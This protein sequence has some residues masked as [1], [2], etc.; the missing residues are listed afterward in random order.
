M[1]FKGSTNCTS[2]EKRSGSLGGGAQ[3]KCA[4]GHMALRVSFSG[5]HDPRTSKGKVQKH[6]P[7]EA[8]LALHLSVFSVFSTWSQTE[9]DQCLAS[10]QMNKNYLPSKYSIPDT[11]LVAS[12]FN[13]K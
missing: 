7:F 5:Y 6:S 4:Q 3:V 11:L 13:L 12:Q 2:Q 1:G 9:K 10:K 8:V